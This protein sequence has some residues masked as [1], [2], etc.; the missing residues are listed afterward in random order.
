MGVTLAFTMRRAVHAAVIQPAGVRGLLVIC[1]S[2]RGDA[3]GPG[4]VRLP[5]PA[6]VHCSAGAAALVLGIGWR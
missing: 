3:S 2:D 6:G 4:G 5:R 1:G